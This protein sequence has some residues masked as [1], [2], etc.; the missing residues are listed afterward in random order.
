M[1]KQLVRGVGNKIVVNSF[2]PSHSTQVAGGGRSSGHT[3]QGKKFVRRPPQWKKKVN[4]NVVWF[5]QYHSAL[6][7]DGVIQEDLFLSGAWRAGDGV[8]P[9]RF[10]LAIPAKDERVFA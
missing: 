2:N 1:V 4:H 3:G 6:E 9:E 10:C 7:M 8:N 5:L